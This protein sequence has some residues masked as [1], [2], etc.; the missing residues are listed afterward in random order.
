MLQVI[1]ASSI[2]ELIQQ[3]IPSDIRL[4]SSFNLAPRRATVEFLTK[5]GRSRIR[6]R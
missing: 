4:K 2:D 3:T 5:L 6:I 1:G